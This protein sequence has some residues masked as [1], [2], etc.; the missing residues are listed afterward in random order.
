V[1]QLDALRRRAGGLTILLWTQLGALLGFAVLLFITYQLY[2]VFQPFVAPIAWAIIL[3]FAFQ[4]IHHLLRRRLGNRPNLVALLA[5]AVVT[6]AVAIPAFAISSIL[7][8]E[9]VS[10]IQNAR[11]FLQAGG[12]PGWTRHRSTSEGS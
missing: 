1:K 2:Q 10:A 12:F 4:P 7:T 6:V 8:H 9:A 5:T 11:R 3:R